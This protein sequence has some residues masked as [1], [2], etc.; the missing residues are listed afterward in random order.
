MK[1]KTFALIALGA[2]LFFTSCQ[3]Q[4]GKPLEAYKNITAQ[5]SVSYYLGMSLA[6]IYSQQTAMDTTLRGNQSK[7]EFLKGFQEGM[8]MMDN[9]SKAYQQGVMM[10]MQ[11]VGMVKQMDERF[12]IKVSGTIMS[13]AYR[14]ALRNEKSPEVQGAQ[15]NL[16]RIM[17]RLEVQAEAR[18]ASEIA[19]AMRK[20]GGNGYKSIDQN[21]MLKVVKPGSGANFK[22][23]D[24][25]KLS[26]IVKDQKGKKV[27]M[28]SNP[29]I[30]GVLG[31]RIPLEMF[32][33]KALLS[34]NPGETA[35]LLV[36]ASII[37]QNRAEQYGYKNVDIFRVTLQAAMAPAAPAEAAAPA[38]SAEAKVVPAGN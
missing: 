37:F 19:E 16:S 24:N 34:M 7:E 36:P 10:G 26:M 30:V 38:A 15:E 25:V 8:K 9:G 31:Q 17:N 32:F 28:L 13:D 35:E 2:G 18:E 33:G 23:G 6:G 29:E 20:A 21:V 1:L 3:N 22:Q 27:D 4:K 12:G 11:S 14:Y 5:D